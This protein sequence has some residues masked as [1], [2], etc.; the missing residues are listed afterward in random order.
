MLEVVEGP[1]VHFIYFLTIFFLSVFTYSFIFYPL[2][3]TNNLSAR[4]KTDASTIDKEEK[5]EQN[6]FLL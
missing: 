3:T 2:P 1:S 5:E 6:Y 4:V